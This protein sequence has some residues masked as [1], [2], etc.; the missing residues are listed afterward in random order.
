[1]DGVPMPKK[2]LAI[3]VLIVLLFGLFGCVAGAKISGSIFVPPQPICVVPPLHNLIIR[4]INLTGCGFENS[5]LME[6]ALRR[7]LVA[8]G[9][10]FG[11]NGVLLTG[12]VKI[13]KNGHH[14]LCRATMV[15]NI[16]SFGLVRLCS[17]VGVEVTRYGKTVSIYPQDYQQAAQLIVQDFIWQN[18]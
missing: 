15:V 12:N 1:M 2:I 5:F 6:N 14:S 10:R 17:S 8:A 4:S 16:E 11:P 7:E 18:H 3:A 9:A 13:I